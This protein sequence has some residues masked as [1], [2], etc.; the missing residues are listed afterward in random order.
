M[1]VGRELVARGELLERLALEVMGEDDVLERRPLEQLAGR[2]EL[3][4]YRHTGFWDCMDTYKDTLLLN[5][6]WERG[7]APW[8][9]LVET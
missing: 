4:A 5:E 1:A 7:E 2:N 6:L 8:R 9:A 3:A